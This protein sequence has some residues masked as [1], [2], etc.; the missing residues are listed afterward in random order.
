LAFISEVAKLTKFLRR[1]LW[2]SNL[3]FWR[4]RK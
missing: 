4:K 1:F 2:R 3:K